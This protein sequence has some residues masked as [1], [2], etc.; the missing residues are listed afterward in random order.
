[1]HDWTLQSIH[2]D[3]ARG[4]AKIELKDSM[5]M[6]R[7]IEINELKSVTI[8]RRNPWGESV[9]INEAIYLVNEGGEHALIVEMQSGDYIKVEAG[10]ISKL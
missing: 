1:M 8:P 5:S 7:F 3:W 9:S 6:V 10:F 2:V 4:V